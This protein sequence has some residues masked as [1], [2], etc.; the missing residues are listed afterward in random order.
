MGA[1]WGEGRGKGAGERVLATEMESMGREVG[2]TIVAFC[3]ID[4]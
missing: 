2:G 3:E 4:T 1:K